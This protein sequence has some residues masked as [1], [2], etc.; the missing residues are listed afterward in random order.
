MVKTDRIL[1]KGKAFWLFPIKSYLFLLLLIA[2]C[3]FISEK[4]NYYWPTLT[5]ITQL[6][7]I[8]II[9]SALRGIWLFLRMIFERYELTESELKI[10]TGILN[11]RVDSLDVLRIKDVYSY[12]PIYYAPFN[13]ADVTLRTVDRTHPVVVLKGINHF[14]QLKDIFAKFIRKNLAQS[15]IIE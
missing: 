12:K 3:L 9:F 1:W 10:Y 14:E 7:S 15:L 6:L 8:L 4:I 11:K 5:S 13:V 2:M